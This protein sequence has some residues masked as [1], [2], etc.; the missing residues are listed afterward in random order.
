M[1]A[2]LSPMLASLITGLVG[3]AEVEIIQGRAGA[4]V[5]AL[6]AESGASVVI[7]PGDGR[8]MSDIGQRLLDDRARFR[9]LA[10]VDHA[11]SGV[12]GDL[13]VRTIGLE[14]ISKASLLAAM[15]GDLASV[16]PAR[17]AG[18]RGAPGDPR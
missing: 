14:D 13:A 18:P 1:L 2:G 11:S 9:V 16:P 8:E 15:T 3:S 6:V 12:V 5:S 10:L 4:D 17:S 7:V